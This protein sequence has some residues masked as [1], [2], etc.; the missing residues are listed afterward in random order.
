MQ[1]SMILVVPFIRIFVFSNLNIKFVIILDYEILELE[2]N[3]RNEKADRD[4]TNRVKVVADKV[5]KNL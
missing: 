5:D 4:I 3:S 1:H 2:E